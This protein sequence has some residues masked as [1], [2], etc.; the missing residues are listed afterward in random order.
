MA[1]KT[2]NGEGQERTERFKGPNFWPDL[3]RRKIKVTLLSGQ[4]ITGEL[5]AFNPYEVKIAIF[6]RGEIILFKHSISFVEVVR[7]KQ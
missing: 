2:D 6:N 1:E 3:L 4:S 7:D 5:V